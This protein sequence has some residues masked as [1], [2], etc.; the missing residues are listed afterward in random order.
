MSRSNFDKMLQEL[1]A[2]EPYFREREEAL[3]REL[4]EFEERL[5]RE[6]Q[7]GE[8]TEEAATQDTEHQGER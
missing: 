1:Y 8:N 5:K 4:K 6:Q 3:T 7:E 2:Y